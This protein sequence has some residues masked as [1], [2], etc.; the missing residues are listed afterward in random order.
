MCSNCL[1]SFRMNLS[2]TTICIHFHEEITLS[3]FLP[4][5]TCFSRL[6]ILSMSHSQKSV[7]V[8]V[9]VSPQKVQ[10]GHSEGETGHRHPVLSEMWFIYSFALFERCLDFSLSLSMSWCSSQSLWL[11]ISNSERRTV[12]SSVSSSP[13][14]LL[15]S[16]LLIF[17]LY[18]AVDAFFPFSSRVPLL[19]LYGSD[20]PQFP[21]EMNRS[22]FSPLESYRKNKKSTKVKRVFYPQD[23][24]HP[25]KQ[26]RERERERN[27]RQTFFL[28]RAVLRQFVQVTR[29]NELR[30]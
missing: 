21:S 24:L 11:R 4:V 26:K 28:L 7:D 27:D 13:I 1:N 23:I 25:S 17:Y 10:T 8:F 16:F 14:Y 12:H 30:T 3:L 18:G 29:G 22:S 5:L 9:D 20:P 2:D 15:P 19:S 6:R